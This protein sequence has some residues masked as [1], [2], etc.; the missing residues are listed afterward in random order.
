MSDQAQIQPED[1][2]IQTQQA[3][4]EELAKNP[5]D[6]DPEPEPS[7]SDP[8][9]NQAADPSVDDSVDTYRKSSS[10]KGAG[11]N[12][13]CQE[14]IAERQVRLNTMSSSIRVGF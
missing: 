12:L 1:E 10:I 2:S 11:P 8:V 9:G 7:P 6:T 14:T 4:D 5:A 13:L 3:P